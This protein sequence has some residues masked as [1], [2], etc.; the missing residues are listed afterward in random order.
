MG[1]KIVIWYLSVGFI[2]LERNISLV[3]IKIN[4]HKFVFEIFGI[5]QT[6]LNKKWNNPI[7]SWDT[8]LLIKIF[9]IEMSMC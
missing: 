1:K 3:V 6:L 9:K 7:K 8:L 4:D 5:S 2:D